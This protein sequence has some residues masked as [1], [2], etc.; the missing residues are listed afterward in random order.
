VN[1]VV[2]FYDATQALTWSL[3]VWQ[4]EVKIFQSVEIHDYIL[5]VVMDFNFDEF[6]G[7]GG[8]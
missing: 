4:R 3:L 2:H 7:L 1:W 5:D 6:E 8:F